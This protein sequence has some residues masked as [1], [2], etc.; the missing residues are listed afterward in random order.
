MSFID[1]CLQIE[2]LQGTYHQKHRSGKYEV[3][4]KVWKESIVCKKEKVD[5]FGK[6]VFAYIVLDSVRKGKNREILK[7]DD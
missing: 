5:L 2:T 3:R 4:S 1:T 7:L 6:P